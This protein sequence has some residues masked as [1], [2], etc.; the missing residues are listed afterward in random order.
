MERKP[1]TFYEAYPQSVM[2]TVK[3]SIVYQFL[4]RD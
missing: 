1:N 3:V 4:S 2:D